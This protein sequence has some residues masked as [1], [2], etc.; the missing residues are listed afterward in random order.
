MIRV[1]WKGLAARPVRTA[2][3]TLAI[4][5][6]VAFVCAAYTLTDTMRNAA[7]SL[8]A[9]AYDGTDAVVVAKTAF[10][11]SQTSD[12]RAQA[13][14]LPASTLDAVR[15]APGVSVAAGDITDTAEIVG[16]DGKVAD[17][18]PYFGVGFDARTPG[19]EQLTPFRLRAG[20]WAAGPGEVVIDQG[21]ASREHYAVGDTVRVSTRG[22]AQRFRL[23]GV[24]SFA[25]VKTIGRATAA[26][27]DLKTAQGL[28]AKDGYDRILVA[29]GDRRS[30]AAAAGPRAE[31]RTAADDD[32]FT[33]DSLRTFVNIIRAILLAFA[34]VAVLVGAFTIFNTL[35]I[36]VAQRTRE[37]GLLRMVGASRRQVR[38]NVLLE[39]LV[40]GLLASGIGIAA[41][42]GIEAGLNALFRAVGLELPATGTVISARTLI[43]SVAVG[44][45][46]T[47]LAAALPARRATRIAPVAA[48][49]DADP[50]GARVRRFARFV[51]AVASVAGRP[52][53][54]LGGSAGRL[55]RRNAMRNPGRTAV[56]ASALT[57]G[58][59]LVTAVTVVA[60][61]LDNQSRGTLDRHIRAQAVITGAD[62]WSPIDPAVER[63]VA[64][65]GGR[66]GIRAVTSLRQDGA[67]AFGSQEG[68]N[69]VD[70]ARISALFGYD[71]TAGGPQ[72]LTTLGRDGAVLD[73][74]FARTHHLRVGS[75]L[76][77]T[78][79][80]GTTLHLTVRGIEDSPVL[81]VLG[82][83]PI[84]I[85]QAAYDGAFDNAR[86]RLTLVDGPVDA[87]NRALAPFP[88]AKVLSKAEFI[89]DQTQF[90]GQILAIL[91]VLLAL[92]VIVSLFGIVNTLVLST[93]ERTRELGTLRA[94][95]MSRRQVRRM[96]RHESVITALI[97][98]ALGIAAGLA[99]AGGLVAWLGSYGLELA[100]PAGSLVAVAIV[101]AL[102]GVLAAAWPAR[103]ASRIDVLRALAYE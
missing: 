86:N 63:A 31:V 10:R 54:R 76:D 94:V 101:A 90:I 91:W 45:L 7:S 14:T 53:E 11:G 65:A 56:T 92:A 84:T 62:G 51:R 16:R 29:G 39:A 52:A 95:G 18:G 89:D 3:T 85:S 49:R 15:R 68:V 80:R 8:S 69:A 75:R 35:S 24:A 57:I 19:A 36:T 50:D 41:G 25:S 60:Q 58:V 30:L 59:A 26:I 13:P 43:V 96:V 93:F 37:F 102:A 42:L 5:V 6:G 1:T 100:I 79:M 17:G 74:G 99:L 2:L 4:V 64:A 21:T 82:L 103:R 55:A 77:I 34:G 22:A 81:D 32:R 67:L 97:G 28:F 9:A 73:E 72:A 66:A 48:L 38:R 33:F 87:V 23:V 40:V 46:T 47:V 12:I 88:D 44:T 70:P 27:F 78:S 20:R 98:A 61:G 71:W 83:G